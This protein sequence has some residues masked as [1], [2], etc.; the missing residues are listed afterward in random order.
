MGDRNSG[1][2]RG[3]DP[4]CH[5]GNNFHRNIARRQICS[6]LTATAK[7]KRVTTLQTHNAFVSFRHIHK[8]CIGAGLRHG[9]VSASLSNELAFAMLRNEIEHFLRH[10]GVV[11]Q[12]ITSRQQAMGL[13]REQFWITRAST[14]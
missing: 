2:G 3:R 8:H 10:K 4:G 5:S 6:L 14:H 9:V 1:V 7:Q 13:Q 11:N 12:G